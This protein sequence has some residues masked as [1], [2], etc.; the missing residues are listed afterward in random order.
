MLAQ[1]VPTWWQAHPVDMH[2]IDPGSSWQH[3]HNESF[4]GVWRDGCLDRWL[5][6]SV[7]EARRIITY[8]LE[9]Y[10]HQRPHEAL[11]GLTPRACVAQSN[12]SLEIAV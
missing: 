4:H 3:G 11:E 5:L 12:A 9:E 2:C 10:N 1:R 8:G 6:T 7:Y